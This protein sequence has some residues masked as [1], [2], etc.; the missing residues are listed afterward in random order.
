[1]NEAPTRQALRATFNQIATLHALNGPFNSGLDLLSHKVPESKQYH[2]GD[3]R[4]EAHS[5]SSLCNGC[6]LHIQRNEHTLAKD[7]A[8]AGRKSEHHYLNSHYCRYKE[9]RVSIHGFLIHHCA[10]AAS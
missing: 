5:K 1:M 4:Q 2:D 9:P 8:V 3:G 10:A 7:G 6:D